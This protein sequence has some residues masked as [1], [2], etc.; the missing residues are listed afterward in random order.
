[1]LLKI[2]V[3]EDDESKREAIRAVLSKQKKKTEVVFAH[4]VRKAID[5]LCESNFDLVVADMSLPTYDIQT[6]ERGGTPRPFGGI[7]VF[8]YLERIENPIPVVVVTSYPILTDGK[9]SLSYVDLQNQLSKEF[10]ENYIGLVYYDSTYAD[11]EHAFSK[12]LNQN[13]YGAK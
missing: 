7:E 12:I 11:W 2:L 3:V 13:F 4:S 6:R 8:E 10:P 1:M 9:K 5:C